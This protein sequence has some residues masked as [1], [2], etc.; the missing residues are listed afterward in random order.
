MIYDD[1]TE[2]EVKVSGTFHIIDYSEQGAKIKQV[3]K[4]KKDMRRK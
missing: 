2:F 1:E 4:N 3:I